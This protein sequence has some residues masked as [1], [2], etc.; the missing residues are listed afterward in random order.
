MVTLTVTCKIPVAIAFIFTV[1]AVSLVGAAFGLGV[2]LPLK[3]PTVMTLVIIT[4]GGSILMR[5][6]TM[7][8]WGK[9]PVFM[10][11]F[12]SGKIIK[13][14]GAVVQ[15][16]TLWIFGIAAVVVTLLYIFFDW[17]ITGKAMRACS[18]DREASQLMGINVKWVVLLSFVFS[19]ALGAVA[20]I[21]YT[22]VASMEY[23][24]G[25][26][27]G[28][29]GFETSII[30]GLGNGLGAVIAGLLLGLFESFSAGFIT[31]TYKEAISLGLLLLVLF[32]RPSGILGKS[33]L[34]KLKEF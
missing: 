1:M 5:A 25:A 30:G 21:V 18:E 33:E 17:T 13:V 24:R 16:H 28:L 10:E 22:P 34:A 31:S 15:V 4:I 6:I 26:I 23:G 20:G 3:K 2:I 14:M 9:Y 8:I 32:V 7:L 27:L 29:K 19:A 12:S 11:P